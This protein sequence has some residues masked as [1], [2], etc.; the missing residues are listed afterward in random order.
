MFCSIDQSMFVIMN[1]WETAT[2]ATYSQ[3]LAV[4]ILVSWVHSRFVTQ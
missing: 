4:V 3:M 2:L 1:F